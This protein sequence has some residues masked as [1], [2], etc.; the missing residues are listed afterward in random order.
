MMLTRTLTVLIVTLALAPAALA[1]PRPRELSDREKAYGQR[2]AHALDRE[3]GT[4][5]PTAD[6][7]VRPL[8]ST[9]YLPTG[10]RGIRVDLGQDLE[11]TRL[12]FK[13]PEDAQE[14]VRELLRGTPNVPMVAELRGDQLVVARG[15]TLNDPDVARHVRLAMWEGL[16]APSDVNDASLTR[17]E[18][19]SALS[20]RLKTGPLRDFVEEWNKL[21]RSNAR[22]RRDG[23]R[24]LDATRA[25]VDH[26]M[27]F[28]VRL[29][30]D[31]D[32]ASF[33]LANESR[34]APLVSAHFDALGG[35]PGT[36]QSVTAQSW[37]AQTPGMRKILD[38]LW[39]SA[40]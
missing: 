36:V 27:G 30:S 7:L 14:F 1:Q 29:R 33:W 22:H 20:T 23:S 11:V 13:T 35:H 15:M 18:T 6:E 25:V 17:L 24:A 28:K 31:E 21:I 26:P 4:V 39:T 37:P 5:T 19:G 3:G 16:P 32:G 40:P 12:R 9:L 34:D 2:L 8:D 10:A 38:G